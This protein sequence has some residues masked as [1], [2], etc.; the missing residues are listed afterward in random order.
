MKYFCDVN[1]TEHEVELVER[2]GELKVSVDGQAVDFRF[3]ETDGLGQAVLIFEGR[4]YGVS[5]EGST[6]EVDL[7]LAGYDYHVEIENERER[8]AHAAAR[9]ASRGGGDVKAVMPGL[10][11]KLLVEQGQA[12]SKGT[13]LLVLEAMKMQNEISADADGVISKIH[14]Q[15]GQAVS[16]GAK[17]VTITIPTDS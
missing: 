5:I 17:L 1:G 7:S 6:T 3:E 15:E 16:A 14:V 13:P 8:A 10:V 11:V 4:S 2:L 12:V 9:A